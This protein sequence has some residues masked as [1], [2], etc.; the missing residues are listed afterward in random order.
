MKLGKLILI[1]SISLVA[2]IA[3]AQRIKYS[4]PE[5]RLPTD[6]TFDVNPDNPRP[7]YPR[8]SMKRAEWKSLNGRWHFTKSNKDDER[9]ER[10]GAYEYELT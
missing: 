8:P 10:Y 7:E 1:C 5:F 6:W 4:S 9:P 2:S 3:D